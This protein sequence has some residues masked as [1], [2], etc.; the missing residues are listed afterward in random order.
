MNNAQSLKGASIAVGMTLI[1]EDCT[2]NN[3]HYELKVNSIEECLNGQILVQGAL[4][5]IFDNGVRFSLPNDWRILNPNEEYQ[6]INQNEVI[7]H[8]ENIFEDA[9]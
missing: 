5:Q 7:K 2:R 4:M 3:A 9:Q 8:I 6:V 1:F